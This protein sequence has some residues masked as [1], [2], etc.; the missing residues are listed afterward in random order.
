MPAI[1]EKRRFGKSGVEVTAL[2]FGAATIGNLFRPVSDE[3]AHAMIQRAWD[4]GV[5]LFDTAPMY[6]H[7]LSEYRLNEA[8]RGKP[9]DEYVM[10]TKV[11]RLLRPTD[12]ALFDPDPWVEVPP[13]AVE[14]DYS[15]EGTLRSIEDSLQ[16]LG[17]HR[18]DLVFIHDVDVFT[19]GPVEQPKRFE[20]AIAGAVPALERLRDEGV[21]AGYGFGVNE[22]EVCYEAAKRADVDCFVLA[23][24][25][26]LIDQESL[27]GFLPLCEERNIAIM[28]GGGYNSGILATGAIPGAKYNYGPA[29]GEIMERVGRI[30]EVCAAHDVALPAAALQFCVAHPAVPTIIPG[31]RTV[32]QFEQS[33]KYM[34]ASIPEEFW[35]D[36]KAEGLIRLDAPTPAS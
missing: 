31:G 34:G 19:H 9:R 13:F 8:L 33:A 26:T 22:W 18:I 7:G 25:Y 20:E 28:L 14:Y 29:P 16:R 35:A 30:E 15:Y 4:L 1:S 24:R 11:G 32:A 21:I 2:G 27:D 5:R 6:G 12:P 10:S 23:G 3:M 17:T 36:L